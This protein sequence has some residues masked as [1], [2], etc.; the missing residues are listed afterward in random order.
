ME[1]NAQNRSNNL[2]Q[3]WGM[4]YDNGEIPYFDYNAFKKMRE[5]N[6]D[7]YSLS[8]T[9]R[10]TLAY[11]ATGTY[12]YQGRYSLTGTFRYE[13][14]NRLGKARSARWLPTWN[15]G[16]AWNMHEE[17]FFEKLQ[18]TFS[19]FTLK[20]S[21][22]LTADAGPADV[23]NSFVNINSYTPWR[24]SASVGESG[25]HI[26]ELENGDLTYEKKHEINVGVDMGFFNNR[27]NIEFAWYKRN[28]Y[29]LIGAVLTQGV[30]GETRRNANLASM[31]S[32]GYEVS[33]STQNIVTKNFQWSTD[34]IFG[35]S[36]TKITD[37]KSQTY[38]FD[39]VTGYGQREG[40]DWGSIFSI[41]FAG[42][43]EDGF[44]TYLWNGEIID[45]SN[46]GAINF[47]QIQD[48][49]FLKYEGPRDPTITGSFGNIFTYKGLKLNVFITYSA[50]NK[51]RLDPQFSSTYNDLDATPKDFKNRWM[52]PGEEKITNIPV[53]PSARDNQKY[54]NLNYAYNA[55]N[56]SDVRI[57]DGGFIRMKEISLTYDF[58]KSLLGSQNILK[59]LSLKV[60]ATNLFLI[61]A[62]DK[63]NGQDPEF[64]NSG[65]V[66]AP[67]PKQFTFTLRAGF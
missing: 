45:K 65:G 61:Y 38:L 14:S 62:D 4:Q 17:K 54:S 63:L 67:V 18:P 53:I 46:Y 29:D 8:N 42:L 43:D 35:Y 51:V 39:L 9:R 5:D 10:R 44:P 12:S 59:T 23:T 28:N 31:K 19:H 37:L 3:G 16:F 22:S 50:G 36:K 11:F 27:M 24:P 58:P 66:A 2:F 55:Y 1:A 64:F 52:L 20:S 26:V 60:Q 57:A 33:L 34:F 13:G 47:Q 48:I 15:I 49:D 56:Y 30:G 41:P 40:Y 32:H 25:L 7:Y 6:S 21:Y